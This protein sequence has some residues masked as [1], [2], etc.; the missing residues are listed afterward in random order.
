MDFVCASHPQ[1]QTL[2]IVTHDLQ[3]VRLAMKVFG[4]DCQA[5]LSG[6]LLQVCS[7]SFRYD[8]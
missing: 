8:Q 1:G 3:K 6:C 7:V 4:V 2:I 5:F